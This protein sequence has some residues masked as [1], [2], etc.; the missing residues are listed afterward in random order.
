MWKKIDF[1]SQ[2]MCMWK[3]GLGDLVA[4][5]NC[6]LFILWRFLGRCVRWLLGRAALLGAILGRRPHLV[7]SLT[8]LLQQAPLFKAAK[9]SRD[10]SSRPTKNRL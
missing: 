9:V 6:S 3:W 10:L 5:V 4:A 1:F 2:V 8:P 7:S